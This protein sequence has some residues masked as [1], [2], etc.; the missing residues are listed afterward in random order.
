MPALHDVA[1][2]DL[3]L[4]RVLGALLDER[5]LTRAGKRLGLTQSATSHALGRLRRLFG[6]PL[7]VRTSRGL[8][9]TA[10]AQELAEPV[11]EAMRALD[12][13]FR[14]EEP[15]VAASA[16]RSFSVATADYGSFV[17]APKL[18]DRLGREAPN[19]DLWLRALDASFEEQLARGDADVVV[20]PARSDGLPAGIRS[21]PL[22]R[23]RFVCLVRKGHPLVKKG[24]D[25]AS[26]TSMRHVFIAPRGT[27]GGVV[28]ETLAQLGKRRRVALA[29][30]HFLL[31]PHVV[32]GSDLVVSVGAR[33]AEAFAEILP[34]RVVDPP[35]KLP[36]FEVRMYWHERHHRDPAQQWFRDAVRGAAEPSSVRA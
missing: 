23:E 11:R 20:A 6:D 28:D 32:A 14:A 29:V 12:R 22:Y 35:V 10:R 13:C 26:W 34:L 8:A 21:R 1:T 30:P 9:P 27:P 7:F 2:V 33:V 16:A 31:A 24:I 36:G 3:N 4:V 15:F 25:L 18:L 5:H 17:L 19:V